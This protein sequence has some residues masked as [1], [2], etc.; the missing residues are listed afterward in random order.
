MKRRNFFKKMIGVITGIV[1]T[2]I[3]IEAK[4]SEALIAA[5]KESDKWAAHMNS[6]F[7]N[8]DTYTVTELPGIRN[9]Q[10]ESKEQFEQ[11]IKDHRMVLFTADGDAYESKDII[12]T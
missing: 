4:E 5:R 1:I 6:I 7:P 12:L 3:V 8:K 10:K 2:P 11:R 9:G